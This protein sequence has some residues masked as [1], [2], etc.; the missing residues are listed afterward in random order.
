MKI[1]MLMLLLFVS[2]SAFSE[3]DEVKYDPSQAA[4]LYSVS[5]ICHAENVGSNY[6]NMLAKTTIPPNNTYILKSSMTEC[7]TDEGRL[8]KRYA[9]HFPELAVLQ[10]QLVAA[11]LKARRDA[12]INAGTPDPAKIKDAQEA[13]DL[14][15]SVQ[16]KEE[17]KS[18]EI[19]ENAKIA[20]ENKNNFY[21][22]NWAP[23]IAVMNYG[24]P[25]I[26][27]VRIESTGEGENKV[28]NI[29]IDREVS[30]NIAIVL[31]THYLWEFGTVANRDT[32]WGF[33]AATNLVKQEGG[34]LTTFAFGPMF[35]V[36][37]KDSSNGISVGLGFFVDTDFKVL[38]DDLTDG[39]VTTYE[40]T[41]KVER[42]VDEM[43]WMLMISS[44]F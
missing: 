3:D 29:Y 40:D 26:D 13:L 42:Q 36:R 28:N 22:F 9:K 44:K 27:D 1:N 8:D 34:P 19:Q 31:E 10:A 24:S 18:K 14:A 32:G 17:E 23:G 7:I 16:E 43:G 35:A 11:R 20:K 25:Y 33:F 41:A 38:R 6:K 2:N 37:D 15:K 12:E 30:T 5:N 21:G 39:A 4:I